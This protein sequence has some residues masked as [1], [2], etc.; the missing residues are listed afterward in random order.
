MKDN[1]G[2]VCLFVRKSLK[3]TDTQIN[4]LIVL[5][6]LAPEILLSFSRSVLQVLFHFV[7]GQKNNYRVLH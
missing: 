5:D 6:I 1:I 4:Q 7:S 2:N 3:N